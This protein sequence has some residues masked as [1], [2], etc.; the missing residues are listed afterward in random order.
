MY[1]STGSTVASQKSAQL[2]HELIILFE[3]E[4]VLEILYVI[5]QDMESRENAQY[6]LLMMELLNHLLRNQVR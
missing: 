4:L 5:A 3:K 6:N 1:Y 2:H